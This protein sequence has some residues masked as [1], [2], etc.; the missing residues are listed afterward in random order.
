MQALAKETN[1]SETTFIL[2]RDAATERRTR[3][4]RA[5]LHHNRRA[6]FRRNPTLGTAMVLRENSG[7]EEIALDLNV[8]RIPV[9]FST[10]DGCLLNNDTARPLNLSRS[11]CA[12]K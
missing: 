11:I 2:P 9:R 1:L 8:G 3:R 10:R 7:A 5:Y 4:A 6:S 12:K